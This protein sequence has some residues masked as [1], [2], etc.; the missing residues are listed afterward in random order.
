MINDTAVKSLLSLVK[1]STI[2]DVEMMAIP[3]VSDLRWCT[4]N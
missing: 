1:Y 4:Y 3:N 2:E